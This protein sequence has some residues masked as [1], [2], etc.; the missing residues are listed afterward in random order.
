MMNLGFLASNNGSSLRAVIAAIEAG[1]LEAQARLVVSNRRAAPALA[2]AEAHGV[3]TAFIPTL[4]DSEQ[5]DARLA[6]TLKDAGV[7]L[8]VLSGYLRKLGPRTLGAFAGRILNVHPALLPKFGGEGM[9][10]R[11]VHEAVL[12]AGEAVSGASVHLVDEYYDHGAVVAQVKTPVLPGDDA[13]A[14]ERRVMAA[15]PQ[16]FVETLQALV[17]GELILPVAGCRP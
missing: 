7:E 10:G 12:A 5:A 1:A 8:V 16:L 4:P 15:E 3:P 14:L 6:A 13:E 17:R 9:F 2:F 11:R